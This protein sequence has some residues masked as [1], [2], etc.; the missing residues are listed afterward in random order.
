MSRLPNPFENADRQNEWSSVAIIASWVNDLIKEHGWDLGPADVEKSGPEGKR[1]DFLLYES[2]RSKQVVLNIEFKQPAFDPFDE[3][4]LKEPS[5]KKAVKRKSPYFGTSN[6]RK[7][8]IFETKRVNAMESEEKQ[9]SGIYELS[10]LYDLDQIRKREQTIKRNLDQFLKEFIEILRGKNEPKRLPIDE[11]LVLRL[12]DKIQALS[13]YYRDLIEKEVLE[14]PK[15]GKELALWFNEQN[16]NFSYQIQDYDR[17]ARQAA[18]L[19]VNKILFY[20]VLQMSRPADLDPLSIPADLTKGGLLKKTLQNYF[21]EVLKIDYETLYSL[22]FIDQIAF[23]EREEVVY[24][25]KELVNALKRYR[26]NELGYEVI[27]RIFENLIP[28][29][30]RHLL[31]QYFTNPDIVDIILRFALRHENDLV[32]DPGCGAGTFLVRAY[33]HKKFMNP[34]LTHEQILPTLWGNDIAKFPAHLSTINLAIDDLSSNENYPRIV[35][36]DFFEWFPG[37]VEIPQSSRKVFLKGLGVGGKEEVVP[38]YFDAIVGNPPYTRQ[39]EIEDLA[40][41]DSEYKEKLIDRA[42]YDGERKIA[43]VS[44]RAGLHAYFFI[45]GTKFLEVGGRFGFVVSNSWLDADYGKGL[46][47]FFF[48]NFKIVAIIESKVE[49][50]FPDADINTCIVLLEKTKDENERDENLVR[51]VLLKKPLRELIPPAQNIW[52]FQKQRFQKIDEIFQAIFAH[53]EFYQDEWFRVFPKKQKELWEEGWDEE[54]NSYQGSKWGKYLRAPEIFFTILKKG[55]DKLI[56]LKQIADVKPGCYSGINDFFYLDQSTI[57]RWGIEQQ[58]LKPLIRTTR[59]INELFVDIDDLGTEVLSCSATKDDLRGKT[60]G[61]LSYINWG[62]KQ[63]TRKR[64]KTAVE[65]PYPKVETVKKRKPAW[66]AIPENNLVPADLFMIYVVN[67]R[68]ICPVSSAPV[69][70][71]RCLHRIFPKKLVDKSI[72]AALLNSTL[73]AFF[74]EVYGRSELGQGALKFET[75]DAK[76]L[77]IINPSLIPEGE[78]QKL[79]RIFNKISSRKIKPIFQ[80]VDLKDRQELDD[81]LLEN[82]LGLSSE[83]KLEVYRTVVDLVKSRLER[84]QSVDNHSKAHGGPNIDLMVETIFKKIDGPTLNI[85]YQKIIAGRKD[86]EEIHLPPLV[87]D[88]KIEKT[89]LAH[90]LSSGKKWIECDTEEEIRYLKIFLDAGWDTV[91][92]PKEKEFLRS[93]LSELEKAFQ[94]TKEALDYYT[95]GILDRG[96]RAH[97]AREVWQK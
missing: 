67:D 41:A 31:G 8:V 5:R 14:N 74:A 13:F 61:V 86:L 45:H 39:E 22:D 65:I 72:F 55:K 2:P 37:K 27:G 47:E 59:Q 48:K 88:P 3:E 54:V 77:L 64:Q 56:S 18:Y 35:Q 70:S 78:K 36:K 82:T 71:D 44:K 38:R 93:V 17:A 49:R 24:Q 26:L 91:L 34:R 57:R 89:L 95:E 66:Y 10:D 81:I 12:H 90:R 85:F 76:N 52:E 92:K 42:L 51:F 23:P 60:E 94:R 7:L 80:E 30:E 96:L 58:Y 20:D 19:L 83:E 53:D 69:V 68:F 40:G 32:F 9:I 33:Q 62:E 28:P 84:A 4:E 21:D 16:W 25:I 75:S 15:F 6:F 11:F 1:P 46:Q 50:W 29:S 73:S 87:G 97:I 43:N 79:L 63:K